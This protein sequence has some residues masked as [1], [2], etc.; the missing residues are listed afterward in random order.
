M[1]RR[2]WTVLLSVIV[3]LSL[4]QVTAMAEG[5]SSKGFLPENDIHYL[6]N[7]PDGDNSWYVSR[8][9]VI[10]ANSGYLLSL[11]NQD[12]SSWGPV[13]SFPEQGA[14]CEIMFYVKNTTSQEISSAVSLYY[15]KDS[16]SPVGK[17]Q[18][19][20]NEFKTFLNTITFGFFFKD[21]VDITISA[22]DKLSGVAKIQYFL[23]DQVYENGSDIPSSGWENAT[24]INHSASFSIDPADWNPDKFNETFFVYARITDFAGNICYLR[25]DGVVIYTDS[26]ASDVSMKFQKGSSEDPAIRVNLNGNTIKTIFNGSYELSLNSDY[27]VNDSEIEFSS[28]Y[29]DSLTAGE[30]TFTISY[31]PAGMDYSDLPGNSEPCTTMISVS[32]M[33]HSLVKTEA[34]AATCIEAG[35]IAYWRCSA[36]GKYFRDENGT[37]PITLEGTVIPAAGHSFEDGKCTVCGAAAAGDEDIQPPKTG[38]NSNMVLWIALLLIAG[39]GFVLAVIVQKRRA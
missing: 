38:D 6:L 9:F 18:I 19:K 28:S 37:T 10:T 2:I 15:K 17:I 26:T 11:G 29:L 24:M 16:T 20:E 36:C 8:D 25:S 31:N 1:K 32:I 35:N 5:Q 34:K 14:N 33:G 3:A 23:S 21:K 22:S 39:S 12:D 30:Y 7:T 27:T 13:L 4:M